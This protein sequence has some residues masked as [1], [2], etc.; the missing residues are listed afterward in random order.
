VQDLSVERAARNEVVFRDANE[1]LQERRLELEVVAGR[2]PFLCECADAYC[3]AVIPLTLEEYEHVR[4][5]PNRFVL[6]PGH[7]TKEADVV[8]E[9]ERYVLVEKQG[10]A[11]AIAEEADARR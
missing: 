6:R 11:G 5:R 10:I 3:K 8:E 7:I 9:T 2:M 4:L 1:F